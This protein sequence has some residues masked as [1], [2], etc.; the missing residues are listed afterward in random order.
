MRCRVVVG[1]HLNTSTLQM[2]VVNVAIILVQQC[3]SQQNRKDGL[4]A[5]P[6]DKMW[7]VTCGPGPTRYSCMVIFLRGDLVQLYL[8]DKIS[9]SP[10]EKQERAGT[11]VR[12]FP[13]V[14]FFIT[15][16]VGRNLYLTLPVKR[17]S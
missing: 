11:V 17:G 8:G 3:D 9:R 6:T 10:G 7:V 12:S 5:V 16:L 15:L 4:I 1:V 14:R 13:M 2:N